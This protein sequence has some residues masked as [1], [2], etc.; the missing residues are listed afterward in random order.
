[1]ALVMEP[2][3][4]CGRLVDSQS[5]CRCLSSPPKP[6]PRDAEIASL[7]AR[8]AELEALQRT[9]VEAYEAAVHSPEDKTKRDAIERAMAALAKG[10]RDG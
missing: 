8:V 3:T 9:A 6:D 7:R 10:G 5:L 4:M 1:M 2:C